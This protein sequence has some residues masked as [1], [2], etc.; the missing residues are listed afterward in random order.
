MFKVQG[1]RLDAGPDVFAN[2]IDIFV[3]K[4]YAE[5]MTKSTQ[6]KERLTQAK[7]A[8]YDELT[9]KP[10]GVFEKWSAFEQIIFDPYDQDFYK[11]DKMLRVLEEVTIEDV[12]QFFETHFIG[13][14]KRK[15]SSQVS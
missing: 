6:F 4:K 14:E 7:Q 11:K 12:V 9:K 1:S 10:T 2:E 13:D 5:M 15:I 3:N 8:I